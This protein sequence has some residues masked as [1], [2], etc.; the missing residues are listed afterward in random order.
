MVNG[1]ILET[2]LQPLSENIMSKIYCLYHGDN[3]CNDGKASA[4]VIREKHPDAECIPVYYNQRAPEMEPNSVIYIVDFCYPPNILQELGAV[5]KSVIVIDHHISAVRKVTEFGLDKIPVNVKMKFDVTGTK[6]G[7][8][9]AWEYCF[10][11]KPHPTIIDYVS[12]Y[13]TWQH[14]H[15]ESIPYYYFISAQGSSIESF[16]IA[17]NTSYREIMATGLALAANAES[18]IQWVIENTLRNILFEGYTVPAVN[19]PHYMVSLTLDK[20]LK[21]NPEYPFA[22]G[23][24]DTDYGRKVRL[25]SRSN[26]EMDVSKLAEKWGGGGHTTA[27]SFKIYRDKEAQEKAFPFYSDHVQEIASF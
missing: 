26:E 2:W 14:K 22:I 27:A 4:W 19:C 7:A 23:Y 24:F 10:P 9:M 21:E 13:D 1:L 3:N 18:N 6:S 15:R 25:C 11:H 20:L 12:D 16:N 5:H 8:L 17:V